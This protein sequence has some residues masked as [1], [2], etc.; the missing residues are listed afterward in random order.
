MNPDNPLGR[1]TDEGRYPA[2]I[3]S[4]R[5]GQNLD[6]D[7]L[8]EGQPVLSLS[9]GGDFLIIWIPACAGMTLCF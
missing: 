3:N 1:H 8:T 5:S 2:K 7:P 4:P 6:I 9:K